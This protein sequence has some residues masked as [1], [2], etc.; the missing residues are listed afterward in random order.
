MLLKGLIKKKYRGGGGWGG[1]EQRGGEALT[2][3]KTVDHTCYIKHK[4][5]ELLLK[6]SQTCCARN[7]KG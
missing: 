7:C 6:Y 1:P 3:N 4:Q 2:T 5:P